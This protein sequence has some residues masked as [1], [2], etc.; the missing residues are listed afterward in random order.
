MLDLLDK[1][2][3]E[4]SRLNNLNR[5][6]KKEDTQMLALMSSFKSLQPSSTIFT[7][8]IHLSKLQSAAKNLKHQTKNLC[9]QIQNRSL[10]SL[11]LRNQPE[12]TEF[13]GYIGKWCDKCFVDSWNRTHITEEHQPGKGKSKHHKPPATADTPSATTPEPQANLAETGTNSEANIA[14]HSSTILDF[15]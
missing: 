15:L 8:N 9:L 1:L 4:Y 7:E 6:T 5:W 12:I 3:I 10:I 2:D 13:K 14:Q 11:H